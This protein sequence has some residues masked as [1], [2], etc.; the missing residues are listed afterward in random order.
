MEGNRISFVCIVSNVQFII[1]V[2]SYVHETPAKIVVYREAMFR[3]AVKLKILIRV[4]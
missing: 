1:K 3:S 2:I 4:E